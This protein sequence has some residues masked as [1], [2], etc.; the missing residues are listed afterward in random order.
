MKYMPYITVAEFLKFVRQ[1]LHI[2]LAFDML[3]GT[4]RVHSLETIQAAAPFDISTW[5]ESVKEISLDQASG[6]TITLKPDEQDEMFNTGT[7]DDAKYSAVWQLKVGEGNTKEEM[8]VGTLIQREES[9]RKLVSSKQLFLSGMLQTGNYDDFPAEVDYNEGSRNQWPLRLMRYTGMK[10]MEPGKYW[11]ESLSYDVSEKDASWYVFQ[12]DSKNIIVRANL[13]ALVLS[14][15]SVDEKI[16]FRTVEGAYVE[17]ICKKI[18]Y[19]Q[20]GGKGLVP[21]EIHAKTLKYEVRTTYSID[22]TNIVPDKAP[23]GMLMMVIACFD[24]VREGLTSGLTV[25]CTVDTY[26]DDGN[27]GY[28]QETFDAIPTVLTEPCDSFGVGGTKRWIVSPE[29][30]FVDTR[31]TLKIWK[32]VPKYIEQMGQKFPFTLN[33]GGYYETEPILL[34]ELRYQSGSEPWMIVY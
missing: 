21:V 10:L 2:S 29:E 11:P 7:G 30:I 17:A 3:K 22:S 19:D 5:F 20:G 34:Y 4:C 15:L 14:S 24:P 13:P 18:S 9:G 27:G 26:I 33:S 6:Y 8:E 25:Q 31:L 16:C 23:D 28:Y 12:N 1:R 32:G